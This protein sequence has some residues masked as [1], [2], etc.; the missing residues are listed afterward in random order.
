MFSFVLTNRGVLEYRALSTVLSGYFLVFGARILPHFFPE[1]F[2]REIS[3]SDDGANTSNQ[4]AARPLVERAGVR[5]AVLLDHLGSHLRRGHS[6]RRASSPPHAS[7]P[8]SDTGATSSCLNCL[9]LKLRAPA[10]FL[11]YTHIARDWRILFVFFMGRRVPSQ[12]FVMRVRSSDAG[13]RPAGVVD[14]STHHRFA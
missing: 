14:Q 8:R 7:A 3:K 4:D 9:S 13:H 6:E 10:I 1:R 12:T 11:L 2:W 5:L